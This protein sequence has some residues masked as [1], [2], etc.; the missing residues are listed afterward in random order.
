MLKEHSGEAH[1]NHKLKEEDVYN[2]RE[3]Y[4]NH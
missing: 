3:A 1:P 2:I 4:A